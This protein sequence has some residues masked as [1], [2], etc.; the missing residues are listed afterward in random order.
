M[1]SIYK[2]FNRASSQVVNQ[3]KNLTMPESEFFVFKKSKPL[4]MFFLSHGGPTFA[5]KHD[6][7]GS[8]LG[9]WNMTKKIGNYIK[10]T[11]KPDFIIV[12]S[13]H[14]QTNAPDEIQVSVPGEGEAWY[15]QNNIVSH[16]IRPDENALIYDFYGFP[17]KFY[18]SQF[19]TIPNKFIADDIVKTLKESDWF[20]AKTSERGIDHGAFVPMKVAFAD[21][22]VQDSKK[23]DV[24]CPVIQVSLAG[25]SDIEI[26]Y[27]LGE[28]LAKYRDLNGVLIF[29]G[30]SV[31]NLRDL[32]RAMMNNNKP[33]EYSK[34]FNTELT[35]ILTET[36]TSKILD[37]FKKLP[38]DPKLSKL[39]RA[40][41]PTNEHFL[42]SVVGAGAARGDECKELYSAASGSLGWNLYRWGVTEDPDL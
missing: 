36:E 12:V 20:Q 7:M 8:N 13:A 18:D 22:E 30:M 16:K 42:P 10:K 11:I 14:W 23:L 26:H 3:V 15:T 6:L 9:A 33:L 4:P 28:A 21:T 1:S 29:S 35:R 41:H 32:G 39:Y 40:A 25:T 17:Q 27:R 31:H 37:E 5:D 24:D 34:P 19:H 38:R 2:I